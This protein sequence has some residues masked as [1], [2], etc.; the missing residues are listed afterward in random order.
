MFIN[1]RFSWWILSVVFKPSVWW[2]CRKS[3]DRIMASHGLSFA[4]NSM[5]IWISCWYPCFRN[6]KKSRRPVEHLVS[7]STTK[8]P[9]SHSAAQ[10][11]SFRKHNFKENMQS[12]TA[13]N[14]SS[15]SRSF[16]ELLKKQLHHQPLW[17]CCG[18]L[19]SLT[20]VVKTASTNLSLSVK[21]LF[22]SAS[23]VL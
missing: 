12:N 19:G 22:F 21:F 4:E 13:A 5:E 1:L 2:I 17:D 8:H 11:T 6:T 9:M 14:H 7:S 15:G 23:R 10:R 20:P 16:A 18:A 3:G